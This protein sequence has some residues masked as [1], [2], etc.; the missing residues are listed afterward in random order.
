MTIY[1]R[2]I[3]DNRP[4]FVTKNLTRIIYFYY[5]SMNT[6]VYKI[7]AIDKDETNITFEIVNNTFY[8]LHS[9]LN[10]TIELIL[11]K[12]II[13][14][15]EDNLIIR[16]WDNQKS[17][18]LDLHI[19]LMY[20]KR[21]IDIPKIIPQTIDGYINLEENISTINFGPLFIENNSEYKFIHYNLISNEYFSLKQISN[22]QT[23][24]YF[25]SLQSYSHQQKHHLLQFQ[26]ELTVIA[27][28][29]SI[30]KLNFSNNLIIYPPLNHLKSHTID[31]H[32][33]L[34]D[35]EMLDRT[36]SLIINLNPHSTYEQFIIDSLPLIREH[37]A[38]IIGVNIRHV[39]IYTFDLKSRNQI[40]LLIAIIRY[41]SRLRPP[42]YI[43]KKLLYNALK[44][45][46]NFLEKILHIKSIENIFITQC[47]LKSCENNG[48]CT[49]QIK[50]NINQYNYFYYQTY[51]RLI[52]KYQWNIKCLCLNYYY[53]QYCQFKQ[54]YQ[55][56]CSSNPCS[57][58]ER[59]IDESST[60][61]SCQC[62]DEPCYLN[63]IL[64]ENSLNCININSP[65]C[66]DS[67]NTLTFDGYS[68]VRMNLTL[69]I[70]KH[71]NLTLTFRT[72]VTQGKLITLITKNKQDLLIIQINNGYINFELNKKIL[73]QINDIIINDGLWH[74]IY[75]SIDYNTNNNYYYLIRLDNVFSNKI[76]LYK[77]I[78][79]NQYQEFL[80]GNDFHG[81]LGNLTLN[82]KIIYLQKSEEQNLFIEHIGTNNGCQLAEIE[83]RTLR[84]YQIKDNIC[85]LYHPCYYGGICSSQ[86]SLSFTCNCLK[87]RFTGRQCQRDLQPCQSHPC[88]FNEQC[89]TSNI[90]YS[91]ISS[92]INLPMSTKNS[93]YMGII[94][95]ICVGILFLLLI[96]SLII[97]CQQKQKEK[98]RKIHLNNDKPQVSA[99]LLIQKSVPDNNNI[100]ESPMQTLLK[101]NQNGKQTIETMA[102]VDTMNNF[103]DKSLQSIDKQQQ[104]QSYESLNH[105]RNDPK[106][107]STIG[108][109]NIPPD[110]FLVHYNS[111]DNG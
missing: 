16:I 88:L 51:Q 78:S 105:R 28:N 64:S 41:P 76:L 61:Y 42:R 52:P 85:L 27:I 47:H 74:K 69:N 108:R 45:S 59:C 83:T 89:I 29:Q 93:L 14:D 97:Y 94:V 23:D 82:N 101:L 75:F 48:R 37:L 19:Y 4:E 60:L 54:D 44:N 111:I 110:N 1:V 40:E 99:P 50:L 3:D 15:Q 67:S 8:K 87:P 98:K 43:H 17:Y 66:R 73:F 90:T 21:E 95:L 6:I 11:I 80:I 20:L 91:C 68:F 39:H 7:E 81:C 63:E 58:L 53:G 72:E 109:M 77:K 5:P 100:I 106:S 103:N 36:L 79:S 31:I 26:I 30:P 38:Q 33:W 86:N 25:N 104:Y 9:F 96:L 62:I 92:L 24:L 46:T 13:N 32:L 55:L 35:R 18:Y 2:N 70:T 12:T 84:Q 102:I 56:P 34:I 65:T 71:F 49:S 107:Y 22:N 10:N 57:A